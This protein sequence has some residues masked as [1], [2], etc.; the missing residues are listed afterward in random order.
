MPA[1]RRAFY[2]KVSLAAD[3]A[4]KKSLVF[5]VL[6]NLTKIEYLQLLLFLNK[7]TLFEPILAYVK[8]NNFTETGLSLISG[9]TGSL[10]SEMSTVK[11][12]YRGT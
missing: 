7:S 9:I 1:F 8:R 5:S 2:P 3:E 4:S 6:K 12:G 10:Y 11:S